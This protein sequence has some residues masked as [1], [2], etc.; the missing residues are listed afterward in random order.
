MEQPE[1]SPGGH[2]LYDEPAVQ[3][4]RIIK[5]SQRLGFTLD[6]VADLIEAAAADAAATPN[7][8]P[9][10]RPSSWR[11]RAG[12]QTWPP[13]ATTSAPRSTRAATI[14]TSVFSAWLQ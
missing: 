1:R 5:A 10:L 3:T 8:R 2:R 14:F 9:A 12:W 13:S 11:S 7:C 6:E 4:L